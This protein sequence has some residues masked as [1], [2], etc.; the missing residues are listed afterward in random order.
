[1]IINTYEEFCSY[2]HVSRE[3]FKKFEIFIEVLLKW[4]KSVNL[5]S[6][7][8][9]N[10]IWKRHFLDS[11][12]LYTYSQDIK[13]NI[14]DIGSGAGFPGMILAMMG[15][16]NVNL[17]ESDQKKCIF[18]REVARLTNTKVKIYN[19]RIEDL[20]Y[21]KPELIISRAL[22]PL[23]KLIEY[24]DNHMNKNIE[25]NKVTPKLLFLKGKNYNNE[26]YDLLKIKKLEIDIFP[27]IT[28]DFGKVLYIKNINL[29]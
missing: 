11:A 17:I 28:D 22:A 18:M 21:M 8:T 16:N 15:N 9:I 23:S 19:C 1:V 29:C 14:L 27:S 4:Q 26:I 5:I 10:T 6:N 3:T 2:Q 12:Q 7:S 20:D 25:E 24:V 13:G